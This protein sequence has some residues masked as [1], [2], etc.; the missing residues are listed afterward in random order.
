[1]VFL[2]LFDNSLVSHNSFFTLES[3]IL[4]IQI[5][6]P[7]FLLKLENYPE[8]LSL[9]WSDPLVYFLSVSQTQLVHSSSQGFYTSFPPLD[10]FPLGHLSV[11]SLQFVGLSSS[12]SSSERLTLTSSFLS[13]QLI[14]VGN[15]HPPLFSLCLLIASP[16]SQK[17]L[18][19]EGKDFIHL[20]TDI[21]TVLRM[22]PDA[23]KVYCMIWMDG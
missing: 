1:M 14:T 12:N 9:L 15:P 23:Q 20:S 2:F 3:D 22:A 13:K 5:I 17:S 10:Y 7:S 16:Y 21:V 18:L 6:Y 8:F 19:Y 11:G 4:K